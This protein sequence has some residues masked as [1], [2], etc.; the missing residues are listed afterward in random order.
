MKFWDYGKHE[1]DGYQQSG[2]IH[3]KFFGTWLRQ[4]HDGKMIIISFGDE[5]M[6]YWLKMGNCFHGNYATP[7]RAA[8][9]ADRLLSANDKVRGCAN[10]EPP[11]EN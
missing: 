2:D 7:E 11:E 5:T 6:R 9:E 1:L 4:L 10:T 3:G 8:L